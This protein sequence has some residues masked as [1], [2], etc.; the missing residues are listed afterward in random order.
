MR[1]EVTIERRADGVA[2]LLL[3]RPR[4]HNALTMAMQA[5]LDEAL[6]SLE[7]DADV[8][9]VVLAGAG[10]RA[11]SSGY[12]L[13]ELGGWSKQQL[14]ASLEQRDEWLWHLAASPLPIVGAIN[15][16]AYGAGAII[17]SC[18][19]MRVGGPLSVF[20]F[21]A[22]AYGG[23]NATWTLPAVVGHARAAELLM[24]A[25]KVQ[26]AEAERFGLLNRVTGQD[27]V[28]SAALEAA[29]MIAQHPPAGPRLVKRLLREHAGRSARARFDAE[30]VAMQTEADPQ[31]PSL[32]SANDR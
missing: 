32:P 2:V 15:G 14:L 3:S 28:V 11:F 18:L 9:C 16:L 22:A 6:T 31:V 1:H 10:G 24:T 17:A 8:R 25:R 12:D 21:T 7:A 20:R 30:S 5:D 23:A 29:S 27:D 19:D 26:P 13:E 4:Q